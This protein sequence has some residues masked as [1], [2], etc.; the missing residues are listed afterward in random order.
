MKPMPRVVRELLRSGWH[1]EA[2]GK[3]FLQAG[4]PRV[5][6]SSGIDWFEL[7]AEVDYGDT[8]ISLPVLLE[9]MRRGD[10]M[11]PLG[12]GSFGLLPED[13]RYESMRNAFLDFYEAHICVESRLFAGMPELLAAISTRI[14]VSNSRWAYWALVKVTPP[15]CGVDGVLAVIG[16]PAFNGPFVQVISPVVGSMLPT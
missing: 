13:S 16:V 7:R 14:A 15:N 4:A 9:A 5:D 8:T 6:V 12:D 10:N 2:E 11:V 1:V 3:A